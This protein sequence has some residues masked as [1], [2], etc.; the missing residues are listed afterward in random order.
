MLVAR[1]RYS[2]LEIIKL[3][4]RAYRVCF[5]ASL[6]FHLIYKINDEAPLRPFF[7]LQAIK[8]AQFIDEKVSL[9]NEETIVRLYDLA[10]QEILLPRSVA[11]CLFTIAAIVRVFVAKIVP[12]IDS[13]LRRRN[14]KTKRKVTWEARQRP[15][16]VGR[17]RK[18]RINEQ[19]KRVID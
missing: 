2:L 13:I 11:Y 15:I 18:V 16:I 10:R 7:K 6:H 1:T 5:R 17:D 4:T 9:S 12:S 19:R 8:D 14:A 3:C